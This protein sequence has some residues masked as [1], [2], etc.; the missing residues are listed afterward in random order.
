MMSK[1]F[2]VELH[3]GSIVTVEANDIEIGENVAVDVKNENGTVTE[4]CGDVVDI[5][6]VTEPNR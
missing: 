5:I 6:D 3:N 4:V 2:K 1:I